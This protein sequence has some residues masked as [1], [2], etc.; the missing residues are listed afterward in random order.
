MIRNS[1]LLV[2]VNFS[3]A[4]YLKL[5]QLQQP[6]LSDQYHVLF[7]DEAQDCTPGN[8]TAIVGQCSGKSTIVIM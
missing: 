8:D 6:C 5:W 1:A 2:T 7:I 3:F 4:G